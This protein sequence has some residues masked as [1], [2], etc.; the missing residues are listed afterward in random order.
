[1][2]SI[3]PTILPRPS[4]LFLCWSSKLGVV[5]VCLYIAGFALPLKWDIFL[6]VLALFSAFIF[7]TRSR[8][9]TTT[10]STLA[11]LVVVFLAATVLSTLMSVDRDRSIRLGM[12]LLPAVLLFFLVAEHF[13]GSQDIRLLYLTFSVVGLVLASTV[14]W[15]AWPTID[16]LNVR[17]LISRLGVPLL[18]VPNDLIFLALIAPLSLVL[19]YRDAPSVCGIIAAFSIL[20]SLC[21]A[22]VVRSRTA[23]LTMLISLVCTTLFTQRR[24]R[25]AIG[26]GAILALFSLG[27]LLNI[28]FSPDSHIVAKV[29][30]EWGTTSGQRIAGRT[31]LWST[32]WTLFLQAPMLG[33]GPHTFG[34]FHPKAPWV[35]N[36]YLEVLAEQG[37]LGLTALGVLLA[38]G[39]SVAWQLR[40]ATNSDVASFGAGALAGLVGFCSAAVVELS[41]VRQ[42]VVIILFVLLGTIAHLW[43]I[44]Q[45]R[46]VN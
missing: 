22:F 16:S 17:D 32:A 3:P 14:L 39:L 45:D 30:R 28:L 7:I 26:L 20:L 29:V 6:L 8:T 37:V 44:N 10:W 18:I 12:Q 34:V 36:L 4:S 13:D 23:V 40:R 5:G 38:Y 42:W 24:R 33:Q 11:L 41:F 35:H 1:M 25:L 31:P 46:E 43:S 19:L 27:L 21:A 9:S 2:S 15:V